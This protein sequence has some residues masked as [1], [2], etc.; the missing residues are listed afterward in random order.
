[1]TRPDPIIS[2]KP[3][4]QDVEAMNNRVNWLEELYVKDGRDKPDHPQHYSYTGL[5]LKYNNE[6]VH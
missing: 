6:H 2:A 3:G 5:H 4:A 1:M